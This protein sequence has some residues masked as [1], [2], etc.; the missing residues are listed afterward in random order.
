M[1]RRV[2][3]RESQ[4]NASAVRPINGTEVRFFR[5]TT[6][7]LQSGDESLEE[8]VGAMAADLFHASSLPSIDA[9]LFNRVNGSPCRGIS[10]T[11]SAA[12][13]VPVAGH[14]D[15]KLLFTM[16]PSDNV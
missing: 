2:A 13:S 10:S 15:E 11:R 5:L 9:L 14:D 3:L 4:A 16:R 8:F 1:S 12:S 7:A 6:Q